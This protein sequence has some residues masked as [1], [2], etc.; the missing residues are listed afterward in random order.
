[1]ARLTSS[2][3]QPDGH[4]LT[5]PD[6]IREDAKTAFL[7]E[8]LNTLNDIFPNVEVDVFRKMLSDFSEESRLHI[9]TEILLKKT[10]E[11]EVARRVVTATTGKLEK[12]QRFRSEAYKSASTA[13]LNQ[14]FKG[15]SK[16]TIRAVLAEHNFDY[17]RSR[18]TLTDIAAKSWRFSF[19]N[20]FRRKSNNIP[21]NPTITNTGC[22]ELDAELYA[23]GQSKRDEQVAQDKDIARLLNEA[24]H[25]AASELVECECC[26]GDYT[27]DEIVACTEGHFFCNNCLTK[28][29]QEGLYGQGRNLVGEKCSIKCLSCAAQPACE[30]FV[31]LEVLV[32]ALPADVYQSL[33][34]KTATDSLD[35]SG[36][37][38]VKCP[39]CAYAEVDELKQYHV[40]RSAKFFFLFAGLALSP[41]IPYYLG[42]VLTTFLII[43]LTLTLRPYILS[44]STIP[45]TDYY[46]SSI[47]MPPRIEQAIKRVQRKRRG[48]LFK[49]RDA[50]CKKESCMECSKEWAPFHKCYEKEEDS[51]R[52]YVEKAMADAVKRTCPLC[53][54]SFVKS[55]G[56]N[57]LTCPCGYIMWADIRKEGYKHFCQHFRQV[58]GTAC[59]ECDR[60]DLYVQEDEGAAIKKAKEEAEMEYFQLHGEPEGWRYRK[61]KVGPD[62]GL[63]GALNSTMRKRNGGMWFFI[64]GLLGVAAISPLKLY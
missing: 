39:F 41:S 55:D 4:K 6:G 15:L 1:M 16:S 31:P 19:T 57:K 12:W 51:V 21:T 10:K 59:V 3:A 40:K 2:S 62:V 48:A 47:S 28:S 50:R 35:K 27:W 8:S 53:H 26:F 32:N 29:V 22:E 49:C 63:N 61:G 58:P 14:E 7:N 43:L 33:E 17:L 38:L 34:D 60:C 5:N 13:V 37:E 46:F 54:V 45:V 25:A 24:E 11:G 18:Q 44:K 30:A 20:F 52:I 56:C 23:A 64:L 42:T 9:I 36:L